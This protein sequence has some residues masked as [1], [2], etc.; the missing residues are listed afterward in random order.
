MD[1]Q[2]EKKWYQKMPHTYLI[3]FIVVLIESEFI[4]FSL[5]LLNL[6]YF[7][8]SSKSLFFPFKYSLI[9][10]FSSTFFVLLLT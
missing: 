5:A 3:L 8:S 2:Q 6:S 1:N 7:S 10:E 4:L 9:N